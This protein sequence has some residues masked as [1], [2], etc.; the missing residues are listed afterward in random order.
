MLEEMSN[1]PEM[2]GHEVFPELYFQDESARLARLNRMMAPAPT[3]K[4][5]LERNM[6]SIDRAIL[7]GDQEEFARL[8]KMRRHIEL[9]WAKY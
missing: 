4:E 9:E 5:M 2:Y 1:V 6:A 3:R 7:S 8:C